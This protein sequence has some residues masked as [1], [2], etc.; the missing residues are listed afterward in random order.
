MVTK[1]QMILGVKFVS[2]E[3]KGIFTVSVPDF[4]ERTG[5]DQFTTWA[6]DEAVYARYSDGNIGIFL[7]S[8]VILILD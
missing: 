8:E 3:D 7:L 1:E 6:G 2:N 5:D 4:D